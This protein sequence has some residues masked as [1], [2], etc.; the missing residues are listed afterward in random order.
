MYKGYWKKKNHRY[1]QIIRKDMDQGAKSTG[2]FGK[3]YVF[4]MILKLFPK[5][6]FFIAKE[7]LVTILYGTG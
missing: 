5:D 1:K 2:S 3:Q 6:Y 4:C 7:K